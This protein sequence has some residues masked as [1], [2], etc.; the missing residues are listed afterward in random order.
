MKHV[1]AESVCCTSIALAGRRETWQVQDLGREKY[2]IEVM[3]V[4]I[5]NLDPNNAGAI[6][7]VKPLVIK[8]TYVQK[9]KIMAYY[10]L[11][12]SQDI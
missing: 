4:M 8:I 10:I 9:G 7:P 3:E 6:L 11:N 1:S 12:E 2:F 5:S